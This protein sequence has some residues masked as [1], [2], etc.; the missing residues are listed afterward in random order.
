MGLGDFL[1]LFFS[2]AAI[3]AVLYACYRFSK[4]MGKKV[5]SVSN[6][7]N[8]KILERVAL[9]QDKG[10]LIAEVCKKYY[11]IG[12]ANNSIEILKE[13]DE[14]DLQ[15]KDSDSSKKFL[16]ILNSTIKSR[17]N[18]KATDK[19]DKDDE[20]ITD[21]GRDEDDEGTKA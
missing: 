15:S 3:A 20:I 16:D 1:T 12:F 5:S 9:T 8:I 6:T 2:F 19:G 4:Y 13:I 7:N 17:M 18:W 11:L 21:A 10:L 14:T